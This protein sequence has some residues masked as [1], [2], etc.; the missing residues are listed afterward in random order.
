[1]AKKEFLFLNVEKSFLNKYNILHLDYSNYP[2]PE[3]NI[4]W[5]CIKKIKISKRQIK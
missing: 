1:M 4:H 3:E 5:I 2:S